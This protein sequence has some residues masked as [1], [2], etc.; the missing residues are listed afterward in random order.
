MF[1][2]RVAHVL[3]LVAYL[4]VCLKALSGD[5]SSWTFALYVGTLVVVSGLWVRVISG[6]D[7]RSDLIATSLAVT[8]TMFLAFVFH[9]EEGLEA[10]N[11]TLNRATALI[12]NYWQRRIF[13]MDTPVDDLARF[14]YSKI[15]LNLIAGWCASL[16]IALSLKF[17]NGPVGVSGRPRRGVEPSRDSSTLTG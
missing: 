1:R 16:G 9:A 6:S 15:S 13:S 4:A 10:Y 5:S 7:R 17:L 11:E 3:I 14:G 12:V 2:L 8:Q